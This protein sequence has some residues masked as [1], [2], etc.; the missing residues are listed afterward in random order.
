MW[1]CSAFFLGYTLTN[2]GGELL[3]HTMPGTS[4]AYL[5]AISPCNVLCIS[6]LMLPDRMLW[7]A[8]GYMADRFSSKAVLEVGVWTWS[9][10]T[11]LTP[12]AARSGIWPL[13]LTRFLTGIGEGTHPPYCRHAALVFYFGSSVD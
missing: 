7:C 2:I 3:P 12:M 6:H 11:M 8:A 9:L 4:T 13:L 5:T 10:F 1:L